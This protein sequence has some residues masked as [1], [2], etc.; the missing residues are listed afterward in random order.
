MKR[1]QVR[2]PMPLAVW[3]TIALAAAAAAPV[4]ALG[5]P[6]AVFQG[7]FE[8]NPTLGHPTKITGTLSVL[9]DAGALTGIQVDL[10]NPVFGKKQFP[11]KEQAE[12]RPTV[13][14]KGQLLLAYKLQGTPHKWYYVLVSDTADGGLTYAGQM[15]RAEETL[16]QIQARF[17]PG[18]TEIPAAWKARGTATL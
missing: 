6:T 7:A 5:A 17:T 11:S 12:A 1:I 15:Y 10:D 4:L 9:H 13:S 18:I 3:A 8:L 2:V 14:G 16:E